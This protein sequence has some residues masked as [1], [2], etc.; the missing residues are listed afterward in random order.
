MIGTTLM[1]M[2]TITDLLQYFNGSTAI[3]GRGPALHHRNK[4]CDE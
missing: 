4:R 3:A 2:D 1:K